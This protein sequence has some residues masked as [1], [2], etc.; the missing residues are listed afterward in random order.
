MLN[1]NQLTGTGSRLNPQRYNPASTT[2]RQDASTRTQGRLSGI[3]VPTTKRQSELQGWS[4][5]SQ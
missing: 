4:M 3:D 2:S 1:L 5:G